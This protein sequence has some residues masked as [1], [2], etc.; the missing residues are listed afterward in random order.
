MSLRIAFGAPPSSLPLPPLRSPVS[1]HFVEHLLPVLHN[2]HRNTPIRLS[3]PSPFSVFARRR[4]GAT[5]DPSLEEEEEEEEELEE[6]E[7]E[8]EEEEDDSPA[9]PFD[10]MRRWLEKKP[11]G[12]GEGKAYDTAVEEEILKEMERSRQAQLASINKLKKDPKVQTKKEGR[13]EKIIDAIPSGTRV[14]LYNLPK[15][16][17]IH[18]DLQVAFKGFPGIINISPVVTGNK[19]TRDPICKGIAFLDLES[20][21]AANRFV[22]MFSKRSIPFGKV[23]KQIICDIVNLHSSSNSPKKLVNTQKLDRLKPI[24]LKNEVP[25]GLVLSEDPSERTSYD[26]SN[27]IAVGK[28][29]KEAPVFVRE[30][31]GHLSDLEV[32][33]SGIEHLSVPILDDIKDGSE[34]EVGE[35]DSNF[36]IQSKEK[37]RKQVM[38]KKKK[39]KSKTERTSQL[40][41]PGS[42]SRLKTKERTVLA[43]VF[44]KYGGKAAVTMSKD[45]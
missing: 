28:K 6:G 16:K 44:S 2:H 8:E 25:A 40:S 23:Q 35:L 22:Q 39:V 27:G 3:N 17:N 29:L 1:F 33:A 37:E 4:R 24:D 18:R 5:W 45:G 14:C 9:M 31:Y 10:E 34:T 13:P 12:F 26:G 7:E 36:S 15:K 21:E 11:Q 19:K 38:S 32:N 41:L 20:K 30:E 43:G 42:I